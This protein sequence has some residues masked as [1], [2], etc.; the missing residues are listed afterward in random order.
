MSNLAEDLVGQMVQELDP[1]SVVTNF[2]VIAE[3]FDSNG[4]RAAYSFTQKDAKRGI[5][6]GYFHMAQLER[7]LVLFEIHLGRNRRDM[8]TTTRRG[9][10]D[11]TKSNQL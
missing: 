1:G 7:M 10:D 8:S 3:G 5:F 11:A 9:S 6:L 2:V 4:E